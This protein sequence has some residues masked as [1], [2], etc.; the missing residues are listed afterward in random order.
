MAREGL[1]GLF[2]SSLRPGHVMWAALWAVL[3]G[4]VLVPPAAMA[5]ALALT[6]VPL[7][8]LA[9]LGRERGGL[10]GDFL[11]TAIIFGEVGAGLG[12][13]LVR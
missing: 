8:G 7:W 9:R 10:G 3:W 4:L 11:G 13:L 1:A 12:W 2:L 5:A 6:L